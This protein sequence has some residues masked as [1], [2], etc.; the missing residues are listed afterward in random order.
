MKSVWFALLALG[1][2]PA[3][4]AD[5]YPPVSY[6]E[7]QL[8]LNTIQ[9]FP[10]QVLFNGRVFSGYYVSATKLPG[11]RYQLILQLK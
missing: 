8:N 4:A 5:I 2:T 10:K 6:L 9:P 7:T 3:Y 11:G 1:V